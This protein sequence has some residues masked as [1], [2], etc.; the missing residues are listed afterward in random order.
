M[1]ITTCPQPM[2]QPLGRMKD[3]S[4]AKQRAPW[5]VN[6]STPC[7]EKLTE[8]L[9]MFRNS[10]AGVASRA[11]SDRAMSLRAA[12]CFPSRTFSLSFRSNGWISSSISLAATRRMP[13]VFHEKNVCFRAFGRVT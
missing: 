6:L 3:L 10:N 7:N 11:R 2:H 4:A 5:L 12:R 1:L 9:P 8:A 13:T